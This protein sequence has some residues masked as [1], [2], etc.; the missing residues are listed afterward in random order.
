MKKYLISFMVFCLG[1]TGTVKAEN[2]DISSLE[3]VI[4]ISPLSASAGSQLDLS[5]RMKNTVAI[6]GFQFDL[7]LPDG[8]TAVTNNNGR[9]KASLTQ[10]RLEEGDE[11]TLTVG[12]Q[13]DGAIRFLCGSQYDETFTGTDGEI[14]T[15]TVTVAANMALG[16]YPILMKTMK[17]TETDISKFYEAELV[18]TTITVTAAV[19]NRVI[20]DETSSVAP[21]ASNGEVDILV[22]R[23]LK[24]GDWS[25]ICLPFDMTEA[26]VYEIFGN[27]VQLAEFTDYEAEYDGNDDVTALIVN[28]AVTNLSEGFYGNYPYLIKTSKDMTEFEVTATI[29]PDEEN[30]VAEYDNG[31]SGKQRKVYGSF[32]GTYH[33]G[34][35]IPAKDLFLSSNK[36]YYSAGKTTLKAFRG[37]FH[38]NEVLSNV[39]DIANVKFSFFLDGT[40]TKVEEM[41]NGQRAMDNV[42]DLSGRKIQNPKQRGVYIVNGKKMTV[43]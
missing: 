9:I 1:L 25:T 3:N 17:L 34:D 11:H 10:A 5:I 8:V 24:A 37:Y 43:K 16:D 33:A 39:D 19:D 14:A 6:R 13:D 20:L 40:A 7:Y 23:T 27:D 26:K 12:A 2:T 36:F 30:A 28:F 22:K 41:G 18:E 42:Y 29:D 35:F 38:F 32:I 15:L 4:Y 21:E 31:K